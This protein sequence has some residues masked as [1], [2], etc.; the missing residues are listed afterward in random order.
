MTFLRELA[1]GDLWATAVAATGA[2]TLTVLT[3]LEAYDA[4]PG[5]LVAWAAASY[6]CTRD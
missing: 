1:R 2:T 3:L 4:L 5:A 6:L